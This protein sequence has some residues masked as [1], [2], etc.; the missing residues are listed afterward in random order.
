ML[1]LKRLRRRLRDDKMNH[2]G[3][4][5]LTREIKEEDL[6][7]VA[8]AID[9]FPQDVL[10]MQYP[11]LDRL[12]VTSYD[13]EIDLTSFA[14]G[15]DSSKGPFVTGYINLRAKRNQIHMMDFTLSRPSLG[16]DVNRLELIIQGHAY[17][18]GETIDL[19]GKD[20]SSF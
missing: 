13:S 9:A 20:T 18:F 11:D 16:K 6:P 12:V 15:R 1:K 3:I 17:A 5:Y 19:K 4:L 2:E 10:T 7:F 14:I 8:R